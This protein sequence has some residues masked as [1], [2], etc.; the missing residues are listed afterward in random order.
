MRRQKKKPTPYIRLPSTVSE[1]FKTNDQIELIS[2]KVEKANVIVV[3]TNKAAVMKYNFRA[4]RFVVVP[5]RKPAEEIKAFRHV[6]K[7]Y[8]HFVLLA[9]PKVSEAS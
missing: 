8:D 2:A 5:K 3:L 9:N 6:E 1:G 7:A 4:E